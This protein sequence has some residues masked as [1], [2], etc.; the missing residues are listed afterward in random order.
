MVIVFT[1]VAVGGKFIGAWAGAKT[2]GLSKED[3]F[4]MG[5]AF[6]PGGA[7][8]I[9]LGLLALELSIISE[10]TFV[11]VVFAALFSSVL[12]GPLLSWTIRKRSGFDAGD[13]LSHKGIIP[14]L[15]GSTK[16]N[17]FV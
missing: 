9:V 6:I 5:I 1:S 3:S 12:V 16:R 7:M 4:S 8:E 11:A 14:E 10:I 2:A 17:N 15:K 13:F